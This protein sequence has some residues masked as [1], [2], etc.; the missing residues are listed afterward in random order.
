MIYLK[1]PSTVITKYMISNT[2][3]VNRLFTWCFE[4][5]WYHLFGIVY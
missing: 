4:T 1:I 3:K 2:F 5:Q